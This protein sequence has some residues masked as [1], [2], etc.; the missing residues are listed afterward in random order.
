MEV[1]LV[2][3]N[4]SLGFSISVAGTMIEGTV[5]YFVSSLR[6]PQR[7]GS[8]TD[9]SFRPALVGPILGAV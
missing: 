5:Y 6:E 8:S 9:C 7:Q 4:V 2:A 3:A 1:G